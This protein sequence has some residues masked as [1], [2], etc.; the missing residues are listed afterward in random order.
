MNHRIR[1]ALGLA[2]AAAGTLLVQLRSKA[3][4]VYQAKHA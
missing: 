3:P 4:A 1:T 2:L